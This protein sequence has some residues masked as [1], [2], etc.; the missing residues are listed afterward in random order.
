MAVN[1]YEES[2]TDTLK[3]LAPTLIVIGV[4]ILIVVIGFF[5]INNFLGKST[6][7]GAT[8]ANAAGLIKDSNPKTGKADSKVKLIYVFDLQCPACKGSNPNMLKIIEQ[9]KDKVQFVYKNFPLPIH[10]QAKPAA[11]AAQAIANQDQAKFFDFKTKVYE[12]QDQL[13]ISMLEEVAKSIGGIDIAKFN[14]DRNSKAVRDIVEAD[15]NN[16]TT[17]EMPKSDFE[18]SNKIGSTPTFILLKDGNIIQW[19]GGDPGLEEVKSRIDKAL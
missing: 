9:Y 15:S 1:T 8:S 14:N 5:A 2:F 11:Y 17:V 10:P 19:W 13:S 7:S 12:Q 16:L 18:S 4:M 3:K 6:T